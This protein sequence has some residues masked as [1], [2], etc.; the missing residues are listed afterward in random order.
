[1][2]FCTS[3]TWRYP[4][5]REICYHLIRTEKI[6]PCGAPY[7]PPGHN[8]VFRQSLRFYFCPC[9]S[10]WWNPQPVNKALNPLVQKSE[11]GFLVLLDTDSF[12]QFLDD[13]RHSVHSHFHMSACPTPSSEYMLAIYFSVNHRY[14]E[15]LL[16][17]RLQ[18]CISNM[19]SFRFWLCL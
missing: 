15:T 19:F 13:P 11:L 12:T 5:C 1:M 4:T 7:R 6:P 8:A 10:F 9:Y 16:F 2:S 3:W 14:V 18:L 17:F